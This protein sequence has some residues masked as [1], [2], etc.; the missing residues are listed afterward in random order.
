[1]NKKCF[2]KIEIWTVSR[3]NNWKTKVALSS[4]TKNNRSYHGIAACW[5][6]YFCIQ[7]NPLCHLQ[8]SRFIN[9]D[10]TNSICLAIMWLY[11][12]KFIWQKDFT[13]LYQALC[14]H[15]D[16]KGLTSMTQ[17]WNFSRTLYL[18]DK[19]VAASWNHQIN[20][21]IQ[22]KER[23]NADSSFCLMNQ[24]SKWASL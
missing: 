11:Y 19:L 16:Q 12:S 18:R 24:R 5:I 8:I 23:Q 4:I 9:I 17:N 6:I 3:K 7:Y 21:I 22:L 15:I 20:Y 14:L 13:I 1:M 10:M 2:L